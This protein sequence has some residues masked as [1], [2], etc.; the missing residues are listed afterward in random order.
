MD[1]NLYDKRLKGEKRAFV[2]TGMQTQNRNLFPFLT[3]ISFFYRQQISE[4]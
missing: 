1:L 3:N 4:I 2:S